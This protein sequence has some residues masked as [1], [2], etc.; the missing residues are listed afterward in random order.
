MIW[1][2]FGK[3]IF[4]SVLIAKCTAR[5]STKLGFILSKRRVCVHNLGLSNH[6]EA[7]AGRTVR[8]GGPASSR[9]DPPTDQG[10]VPWSILGHAYPR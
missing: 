4:S 6:V 1:N 8:G 7:A 2:L 5:R 10:N 3:D 9:C